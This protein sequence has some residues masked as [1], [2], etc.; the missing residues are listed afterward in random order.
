[1]WIIC[2]TEKLVDEVAYVP[3]AQDLPCPDLARCLGGPIA[4]YACHG[5]EAR[6]PPE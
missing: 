2:R 6:D 5:T 3:I 1:M 4:A